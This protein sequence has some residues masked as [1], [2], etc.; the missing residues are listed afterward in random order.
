[1]NGIESCRGFANAR[2]V[3][4]SGLHKYTFY[5]HVKERE[6]R[7]PHR[8]EDIYKLVLKLSRGFSLN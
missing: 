1:M 2:V 5:F 4:F 6:F 8:R 7:F 3:S